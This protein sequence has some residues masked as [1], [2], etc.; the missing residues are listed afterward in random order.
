ML[1]KLLQHGKLVDTNQNYVKEEPKDYVEEK[2]SIYVP[3]FLPYRDLQVLDVTLDVYNSL[4]VVFE[5][6]EEELEVY[7]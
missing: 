3:V 6:V 5:L 2:N 1:N 7:I 4:C